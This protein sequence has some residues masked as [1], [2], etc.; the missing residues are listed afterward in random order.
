V[1][2]K[3]KKSNN[4]EEEEVTCAFGGRV[5]SCGFSVWF[6]LGVERVEGWEGC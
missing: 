1:I 4:E 2:K 5:Q 3:E 6:R